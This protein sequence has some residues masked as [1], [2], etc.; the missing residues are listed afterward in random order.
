MFLRVL[1]TVA[2]VNAG[3]VVALLPAFGAM[4]VV[5][6]AAAAWC[7][8]RRQKSPA[9][10]AGDV[11]LK[12]P[13]SLWSAAKFAALF[14][15]VQLLVALAREYVPGAGTYVV[16]GLAGLTE[17]DAITLTMAQQSRSG[18]DAGVAAIAIALAAL[19]NTL[20]K[21]VM[22]LA[23]GSPPLRRAVGIGT[24]AI[25]AAGGLMALLVRPA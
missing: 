5:G 6:L 22:A 10:T 13:F 23:M 11:P 8:R 17:V 9:S 7:F 14:A 19:S 3:L 20:V 18:L 24:A 2:I 25:V 15:A 1:V 12:N 4:M 21:C 16:A